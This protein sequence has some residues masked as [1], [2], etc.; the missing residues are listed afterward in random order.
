MRVQAEITTFIINNVDDVPATT[1][2]FCQKVAESKALF[3]TDAYLEAVAAQKAGL[4]A[5]ITDRYM[6]KC[7]TCI[8][9]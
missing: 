4:T 7:C 3:V 5:V 1:S 6:S 2:D 8:F 9:G